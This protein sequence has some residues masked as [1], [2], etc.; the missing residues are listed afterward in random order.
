MISD[1][2]KL[3]ESF[4]RRYSESLVLVDRL[5]LMHIVWPSSHYSRENIIYITLLAFQSE[6]F[7]YSAHIR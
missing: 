2:V 7:I 4:V 3:P 1:Y 5:H 6:F